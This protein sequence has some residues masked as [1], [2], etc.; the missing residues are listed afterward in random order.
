[1][2]TEGTILIISKGLP[3]AVKKFVLRM[4]LVETLSTR[5]L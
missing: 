2:V 4:V 3:E 5:E 1:M